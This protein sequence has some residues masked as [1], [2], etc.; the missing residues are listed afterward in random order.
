MSLTNSNSTEGYYLPHHAVIKQIS[1]T[2]KLSVAF[3]ASAKSSNGR[4]FTDN[5][6]VRP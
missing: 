4:S 2:T 6:L 3:E 1:N 5:L